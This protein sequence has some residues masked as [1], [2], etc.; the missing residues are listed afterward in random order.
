MS[1]IVIYCT[2]PDIETAE[3]ISR[4]SVEQRM[5]ACINMIPGITS[6][7]TWDGNIQQDQE[8][9]LVIKST[10]D[11]F[12]DIQNLI[13]DEHPYDLPELIAVP[14]TESSPD[15]LEWIKQCTK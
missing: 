14:I 10:K 9:L 12:G 4:L 5:A 1:A 15:Y 13:N 11:R 6:I 2:C 3:R 7:Y 8:V